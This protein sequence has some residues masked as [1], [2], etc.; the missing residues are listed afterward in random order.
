M[1]STPETPRTVRELYLAHPYPQWTKEERHRLFGVELC[2]YRYLGLADFMRDARFLDAGC[3]T[4][5]RGILP[6]KHFGV[7]EYVGLDQSTA[8]LEIAKRVADEEEFDRCTL[9]EGSVLDIPFPDE[10]F[11]IVVCQGVLHYTS[12]PFSGFEEVVRVCRRGGFVAI[13][14]YNKWNHWRY[15]IQKNNVSRLAGPDVE[16][17]FEVAHRLYAKKAV[18]D[19]NPDEKVTFYNMYCPEKSDHELGELLSWFD[20]LGLTY[21]GSY[22]ALRIRDFISLAQYRSTLLSQYPTRTKYV[23]RLLALAAKLPSFDMTRPPLRK[24]SVFHRFFWQAVYAWQGR[25]GDYSGGAMLCG[26]KI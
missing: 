25:H 2:R 22:P 1:S 14:L 26:R 13:F 23:G 24:P 6:A 17:R 16:R 10:S 3:G 8:S 9:V 19:M 11:D 5:N 15:N 4:G 21:W 20:R 7:R 18:E 12:D